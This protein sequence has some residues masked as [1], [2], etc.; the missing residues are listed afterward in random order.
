VLRLVSGWNQLVA[1][2]HG[3]IQIERQEAGLSVRYTIRFTQLLIVVTIMVGGFLALPVIGANNLSIAGKVA[4]LAIAWL[5]LAGGN[6]AITAF[7]FPR[8]L[9]QAIESSADAA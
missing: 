9:R 3:E 5:W 6:I 7:R 4:V 8:L 1:I 2:S